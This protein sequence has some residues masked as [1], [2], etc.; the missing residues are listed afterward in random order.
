MTPN[1]RGQIFQCSKCKKIVGGE[2]AQE[3]HWYYYHGAEVQCPVEGS[4]WVSSNDYLVVDMLVISS[5]RSSLRD[6]VIY[7]YI[8]SHFRIFTQSIDAIDDTKSQ[9]MLLKQYQCI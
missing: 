6:D 2:H 9:S 8:H 4:D 5:D 7:L 3:E 1:I